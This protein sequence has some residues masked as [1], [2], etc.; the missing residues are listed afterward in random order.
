M[1]QDY[2]EKTPKGRKHERVKKEKKN[3]TLDMGIIKEMMHRTALCLKKT[4]DFGRICSKSGP[5]EGNNRR[6]FCLN[7]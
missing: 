1:Q 4:F 7:F 2:R 5:I 6:I 3:E